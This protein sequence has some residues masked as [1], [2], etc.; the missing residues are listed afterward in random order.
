MIRVTNVLILRPR[1]STAAS[2]EVTTLSVN[3]YPPM[4]HPRGWSD[5]SRDCPTVLVTPTTDDPG[6]FFHDSQKTAAGRTGDRYF[7][8]CDTRH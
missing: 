6:G 1:H 4:N 8:H 5:R 7:T 3:Q 2:F